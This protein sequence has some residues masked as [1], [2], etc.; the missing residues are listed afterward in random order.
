MHGAG[1]ARAI[2]KG[3]RRSCALVSLVLWFPN[4][5]W[6]PS[7]RN[8]VSRFAWRTA[9]CK[10]I[11]FFAGTLL[12]VLAAGL[13]VGRSGKARG[14]QP[15]APAVTAEDRPADRVALA[16]LAQEFS[17][18]FARAK[19]V[20]SQYTEQCEYYDDATGE[21]FRGRQEV[22]RLRGAIPGAPREQDRGPAPIH[23]LC[24]PR[25]GHG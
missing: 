8:S 3:N 25:H 2:E 14:L 1:P 21:V 16:R 18:A 11:N 15:S 4:S 13:M 20:A 9:S 19:A 7:L 6:E 22:E 12:G 24:W 5:V 10:L 23:P 17:K